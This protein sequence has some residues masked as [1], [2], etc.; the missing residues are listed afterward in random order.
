ML[1]PYASVASSDYVD[2]NLRNTSPL[3]IIMLREN[4]TA[5]MSSG[6]AAGEVVKIYAIM[7]TDS[8]LTFEEKEL[9]YNLF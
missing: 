2:L 3:D 9:Y 1:V 8:E 4:K 7:F 6:Y 5:L